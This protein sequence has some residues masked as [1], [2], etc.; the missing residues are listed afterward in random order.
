M[1]SNR[2]IDTFYGLGVTEYVGIPHADAEG[3]TEDGIRAVVKEF[4]RRARRDD[5]LGP[6]FEAHIEEWE[7]H[8]TG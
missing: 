4:Y 7:T 8:L 3:I 6:V 2:R 1:P 5:R